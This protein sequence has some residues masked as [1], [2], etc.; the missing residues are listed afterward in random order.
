MP[1]THNMSRLQCP[2]LSLR[3]H[4]SK[5]QAHY[6]YCLYTFQ[7]QWGVGHGDSSCSH[8]LFLASLGSVLPVYK[9]GW[10]A[11]LGLPA[12]SV[13]IKVTV[14]I[15]LV[16]YCSYFTPS[17]ALL[18]CCSCPFLGHFT[19][20]CSTGRQHESLSP[21]VPGAVVSRPGCC[22]VYRRGG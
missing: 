19:F 22:L 18:L 2:C 4:W 20:C 9:Y 14:V 6:K 10:T 21:V 16:Y 13:N 8:W 12:Y 1:N 5:T 17:V 15:I 11:Q 7:A 3:S